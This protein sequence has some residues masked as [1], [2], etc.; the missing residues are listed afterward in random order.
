MLAALGRLEQAEAVHRQALAIRE[1]EKGRDHFT[2]AQS[3]VNLALVAL[4]R[5]RPAEAAPHVERALAIHEATYGHDH[6][7]VAE[8]LALRA[9]VWRGQAR[10]RE[11]EADLREALRIREAILGPAHPETAVTALWLAELLLAGAGRW[12]EA[13]PVAEAA[14]ATLATVEGADPRDLLRAR[15]AVAEL[16]LRRGDQGGALAAMGI[17]GEGAATAASPDELAAAV[18]AFATRLVAQGLIE[19]ARRIR[20]ASPAG[21]AR[22]R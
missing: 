20:A 1:R 17:A 4:A 8:A 22:G 9:R 18:E 15:T 14:L 11:E 6:A 7:A 19:E 12:D 16:R 5:G 10:P 3:L 2:V 13:T 21:A